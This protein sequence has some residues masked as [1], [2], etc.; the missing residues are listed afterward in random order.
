MK[1]ALQVIEAEMWFLG[2]GKGRTVEAHNR[3]LGRVAAAVFA[4][5]ETPACKWKPLDEDYTATFE[6]GCNEAF[7]FTDGD[8]SMEKSKIKFCP[9]CGGRIITEGG[10]NDMR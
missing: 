1:N 7:Q 10:Y 9:F 3:S 6:T 4:D 2:D 8:H 5:Q